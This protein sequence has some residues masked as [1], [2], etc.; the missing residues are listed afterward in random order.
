MTT[1]AS[2]RCAAVLLTLLL[3]ALA[4][5]STG[6]SSADDPP[7]SPSARSAEAPVKALT[8]GT[9]WGDEQLA[10]AL[11]AK[12]FTEW[13]EK[14]AGDPALGVAMRDDAAFSKEIDCSSPH[15]LELYNVIE[16]D[17]ALTAKV[18]Q[19]ADLLDQKSPLYRSIRD[20]VN[21]RCLAGSP[22]GLAQKKAGGLPVQLGPSLNAEGGLHV[23]WDPFP[24][25]LWAEGQRKFVCTF[26]QDTPG[27]LLFADV[28]TAK[29]PVTARVCLNTPGKYVPC[30]G[31]HQAEDIAE[32]VLNTAIEKKQVN[33]AKAVRKG[34]KGQYVALSDAEYAKLDKVC[35]T[36]LSSVSKVPAG[37]VRPC[38]PGIG[39]AV[40]DA[41]GRLHRLLL[42]PEADRR[43]APDDQRDGLQPGL[44]VTART[45]GG[46]CA[47]PPGP[48]AG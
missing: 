6:S 5:C 8:A 21:D 4:G 47:G 25:D 24:A 48:A 10:D 23:A 38:L 13:V 34:P 33:G 42:R 16:L 45:P 22:Y 7:E 32:M 12:G 17:P 41:V 26:E 28:T 31:R 14:Y 43:P 40:A 37:V 27:T 39:V 9:C 36:F 15:A 11:G 2:G 20:Q 1:R 30:D 29:P 44:G 18:T 35:Q 3:G 19:Y 46:P